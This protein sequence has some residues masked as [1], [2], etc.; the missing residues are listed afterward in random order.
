VVDSSGDDDGHDDD[1][2]V[3][4]WTE[5]RGGYVKGERYKNN[6]SRDLNSASEPSDDTATAKDD[7]THRRL[8]STTSRWND[9]D[10]SRW[11]GTVNRRWWGKSSKAKSSKWEWG[12]C[13]DDWSGGWEP[14]L[15]PPK[16]P[17]VQKRTK[18]VW[19]ENNN[20]N[21]KLNQV[22]KAR[23]RRK[24]VPRANFGGFEPTISPTMEITTQKMRN[25][26][27][28]RKKNVRNKKKDNVNEARIRRKEALGANTAEEGDDTEAGNDDDSSD[29]D[30]LFVWITGAD[31]ETSNDDSSDNDDLFVWIMEEDDETTSRTLYK[32]QPDVA[33][34]KLGFLSDFDYNSSGSGQASNW[35]KPS[36]G[37]WDDDGWDDDGWKWN[38][39]KYEP[40]CIQRQFRCRKKR[41]KWGGGSW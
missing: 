4:V 7:T 22:N 25:K 38:E 33:N 2:D 14:T 13:G 37:G 10:A 3:F 8:S 29:D 15:S 32:V 24:E 16:A 6:H 34:R 18:D 12:S 40:I 35:G 27:A 23:A 26:K 31:G 41:K 11:D 17:T 5:T 9:D 20:N 1:D 28:W 39:R 36:K 30:D 19:R 21:K